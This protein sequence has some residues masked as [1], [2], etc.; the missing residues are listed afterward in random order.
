MTG[1]AT[2]VAVVADD[3]SGAAETASMFLGRRGE[4]TLNLAADARP[5]PTGVTV[6]DLDT[7][8]MTPRDAQ[9]TLR[10]ALDLLP[11]NALLVK[12]IDSLLRGPVGAEIEVL[13][14]RGP[15][16]VVAALPVLRRT[17]DRGVLHLDGVPLHRTRAWAAES[18]LPPHSVAELFGAHRCAHIPTGGADLADAIAKAAAN[19]EIAICDATTDADLDLVVRVGRTVHGAQ[20]VGT[21]AL[22]AAV[23]RTLPATGPGDG[24]RRPSERLLTV[25]GTAEPAAVEQAARLVA[26]GFVPLILDADDLLSGSADPTRLAGALAE[27]HVVVTVDG[28]VVPAS[29]R[30]LSAALGRFVADGQRRHRP[31]LT[32]TGGETARAVVDAIGLTTLVP[33]HEIHHGAVASIASDGRTVVTRPGSFGDASS[34]LT[35]ADHLLSGGPTVHPQQKDT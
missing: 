9:R 8:A 3:L 35:I 18:A 4:L 22:A 19:G 13:A 23:A 15:V 21:A 10:A 20:L 26:A 31:D 7:R 14:E 11:S 32:L 1:P 30:R 5:T 29:A 17:V 12:K 24:A 25:V 28:A 6:T 34:L 33:I 16:I 27:G 2:A